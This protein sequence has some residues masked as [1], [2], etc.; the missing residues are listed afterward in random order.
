LIQYSSIRNKI[1]IRV[2]INPQNYNS[3]GFET[4]YQHGIVVS[5]KIALPAV[6]CLMVKELVAGTLSHMKGTVDY[7][8]YECLR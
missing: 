8:D 7:S 6:E 2:V 5:P 1:K 3:R 4:S